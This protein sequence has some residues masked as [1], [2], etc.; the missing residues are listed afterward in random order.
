VDWPRA[1]FAEGQAVTSRPA[2]RGPAIAVA[3]AW[4]LASLAVAGCDGAQSAL[5]PAGRGAA[6]IADL[7]W[8]MT[9]GFA[10]VW[11]AFVGLAIY[12]YCGRREHGA[13]TGRLVILVGGVVV[14]VIAL[15][16]LLTWG[17]AMMPQLLPS[18]GATLEIEV[19]GHQYWWRVRYLRGE[20]PPVEL[21]N[22]IHLPVGAKVELRLES[23]DVIHSFWI[24]SLGGKVDMIPGRTTRLV[25]E[26][27]RAGVYRGTCAEYCGTS[28]AWMSFHAVVEEPAQFERWLAAQAAPA[29][30]PADPATAAGAEQF[31]ANGCGACHAIRGTAAD[32]VIGPDLTHVGSRRSLAAGALPNDT[33]ALRR[34]IARTTAIKPRVHM[35]AFGALP[36]D[37]ADALA[38]YLAGLK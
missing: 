4:A 23:R 26:P 33:G 3:I 1:G 27:T 36:D 29:A 24:P 13:R 18:S 16:A 8:V 2:P 15:T 32:G 11:T 17:L 28:H 6:R 21:A 22:E 31:V 7:F 38:S 14:P 12:A 34:W 37:A 30:V 9:I 5:A 19:I 25:L 10:V 35:P 20:Q